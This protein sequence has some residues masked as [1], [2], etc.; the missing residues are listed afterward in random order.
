MTPRQIA[1]L[2]GGSSQVRLIRRAREA[3]FTVTVVD[4]N[5][6]AVG[7]TIADRF[8]RADTFDASAVMRALAPAP[9]DAILAAGSDQPVLTAALVAADLGVPHPMTPHIAAGVTNKAV[10]RERLTAA[11]I[12]M[13]PGV[14]LSQERAASIAAGASPLAD[15]LGR[16]APPLVVKPVDSQGQ[17]GV[18][19]VDDVGAEGQRAVAAAAAETRDGRV[20]VER[21]VAGGEVTLSGWV[22]SSGRLDPWAITDRVTVPPAAGPI[23]VC[24]AHRYPS[25]AAEGREAEIVELGQRVTTALGLAE[26]PFYTQ[27]IVDPDGPVRVN[28]VAARLGGAYEEISLPPVVGV[29]PIAVQLDAIGGRPIDAPGERPVSRTAAA[30]LVPLIFCRPGTI[31]A[32]HGVARARAIRGVAAFEMLQ[33]EGTT[34]HAR[35]NSTQRAAFAVIHGAS[36]AAANRCLDELYATFSVVDAAGEDMVEREPSRIRFP[37]V[38]ER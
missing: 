19:R 17:R 3:G 29:D 21:F 6:E 25:V 32:V 1:V 11:A 5:P 26:V 7:A 13:A 34:I 14:V 33:P 35:V 27:F 12:P 22:T 36:R 10:M 23:G 28:E 31:A 24:L 37:G 15:A 30:A 4:R 38:E 18:N 16:L 20:L 8:V 2:G 9:P